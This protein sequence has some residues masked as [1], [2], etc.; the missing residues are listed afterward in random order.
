MYFILEEKFRSRVKSYTFDLSDLKVEDDF[1]RMSL[2]DG[3]AKKMTKIIPRRYVTTTLACKPRNRPKHATTYSDLYIGERTK[4][5]EGSFGVVYKGMYNGDP[6]AIKVIKYTEFDVGFVEE[7][8]KG[9]C[10]IAFHEWHDINAFILMLWR[11]RAPSSF[12][13]GTPQHCSVH[14]SLCGATRH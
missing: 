10:R 14:R 9:M 11:S 8:C 2:L 7:F 13:I 6:V 12:H 5:G 3:I 1:E 4:I